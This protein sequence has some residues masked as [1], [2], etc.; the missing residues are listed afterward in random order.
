MGKDQKNVNGE[1]KAPVPSLRRSTPWPKMAEFLPGM[2][3][4][5]LGQR[6]SMAVPIHPGE[7]PLRAIYQGLEP[8]PHGRLSSTIARTTI[9][10]ISKKFDLS[11]HRIT[12]LSVNCSNTA[13]HT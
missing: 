12:I 13:V 2:A 5:F 1:F 11:S 3:V 6:N 9:P 7:S 10:R 4:S 8:G